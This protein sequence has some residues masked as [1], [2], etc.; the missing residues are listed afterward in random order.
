[1]NRDEIRASTATKVNQPS[2]GTI[3][4]GPQQPWPRAVRGRRAWTPSMAGDPLRQPCI[5]QLEEGTGRLSQLCCKSCRHNPQLRPAAT[6]PGSSA[7]P[8]E[9]PAER[10]FLSRDA[11]LGKTNGRK[12]PISSPLQTGF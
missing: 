9:A 12:H 5:E 6:T 11:V 3:Y 2:L 1:M 8:R 4:Q 10:L 7:A